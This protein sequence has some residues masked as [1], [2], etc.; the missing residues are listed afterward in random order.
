MVH[1]EKITATLMYPDSERKL[2]LTFEGKKTEYCIV[3]KNTEAKKL[4]AR[5]KTLF[6]DN[7]DIKTMKLEL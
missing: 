4:Q 3:L 7:E 1:V 2:F 6:G 5:L